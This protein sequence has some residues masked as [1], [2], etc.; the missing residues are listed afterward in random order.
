[1]G[2]IDAFPE[3]ELSALIRHSYDLVVAKLPRKVQ[4][5][6]PPRAPGFG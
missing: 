4:A 6:L 3:K 5:T 1:V 2:D